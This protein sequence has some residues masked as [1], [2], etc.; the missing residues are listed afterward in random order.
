MSSLVRAN[1]L[2]SGYGDWPVV[3]AALVQPVGGRVAGGRR[4]A[5]G[6]GLTGGR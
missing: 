5:S 2:A 6:V 4:L 3:S 1:W